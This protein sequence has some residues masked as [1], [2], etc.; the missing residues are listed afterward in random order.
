M[1]TETQVE[2]LNRQ[3][4]VTA[5]VIQ[6]LV[7][8]AAIILLQAAVLFVASGRLDWVTAWVYVAVYLIVVSVNSQRYI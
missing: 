6:R 3:S 2:Q 4:D 8:V 1:K 7:Q 5:G